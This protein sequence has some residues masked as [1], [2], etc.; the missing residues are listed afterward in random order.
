MNISFVRTG[1]ASGKV[2]VDKIGQFTNYIISRYEVS[3]ITLGG[4]GFT[5][6]K[7]D[8]KSCTEKTIY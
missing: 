2:F 5:D 1:L 8:I 3:L 7:T 4:F 6:D